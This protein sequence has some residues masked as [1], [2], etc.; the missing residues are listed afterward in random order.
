M[1]TIEK[2]LESRFACGCGQEHAV[3]IR[4][5]VIEPGALDAIPGYLR[6]N[7]YNRVLLVADEHTMEAAGR[8]LLEK[9]AEPQ[10]AG[11]GISAK[12]C[13]LTPD[14]QGDVAA[15]E[16]AIVQV[17][18]ALGDDIG[19]VLA[20]GSGTIHDIVRFACDKTKRAFISV[21]TAPSV[22]GFTSV[23][24]PLILRGFKQT[25][26]AIAPEAM[27][28]DVKIMAKAPQP[29][30]AA[31]FGDMLGKF[32]SLAD[33]EL[34]RELF[35][36]SYCE[37]AAELTRQG[38]QL[39]LDHLDDIARGSELG[40]RKLMEGLTLSGFSMLMVGHSRPA[41]GAEHHLSHYWEMTYLREKRRALLH[42]AKV[43]VAAVLMAE[44]YA[45]LAAM[46]RDE[47]LERL[48]TKPQP[49]RA[50]DERLIR[51]AYG[52]IAPQVIAENFPAAAGAAA[53]TDDGSFAQR[54]AERWD[55]VMAIAGRVPSPERMAAWLTQ[56]GGHARPEELG[57]APD[58]LAESLEN[59]IFVR[60]RF[61]VLRL[62]R[63]I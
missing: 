21:P 16:E 2:W 61:T 46:S 15:N 63:H 35:D 58:L 39:C 33:W 1:S 60:N 23:G 62:M 6:E 48:R 24:A 7:R 25:I 5:I 42:G 9:L 38:L 17:L 43:G 50:H 29:L 41:S 34:G 14:E 59:A 18:L 20:V 52:A 32:T 55:A 26:P 27:F 3:P 44:R 28:A 13:L 54:L 47:A 36:E 30:I 51:A 45:R 56:A 22:D 4:R 10:P 40:V 57:I 49:D 37:T 53:P 11:G 12:V 19:A 8:R 31:G